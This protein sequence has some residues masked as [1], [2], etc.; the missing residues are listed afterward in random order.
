[1]VKIFNLETLINKEKEVKSIT[2]STVRTLEFSL[3]TLKMCSQKATIEA[4]KNFRIKE[5][6]RISNKLQEY[7]K[8]NAASNEKQF[9]NQIEKLRYSIIAGNAEEFSSAMKSVEAKL[10]S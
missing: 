7:A 6:Y 10:R 4:V 9:I 8:A 1:M 5:F 2:R 3:E